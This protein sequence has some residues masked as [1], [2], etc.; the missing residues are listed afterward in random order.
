MAAPAVGIGTGLGIIS[1]IVKT[2][3]VADQGGGHRRMATDAIGLHPFFAG[4]TH[5]DALA[6]LVEGE[7]LGVVQAV[8]GFGYI[9]GQAMASRQMA[10][11][12]FGTTEMS[13]V[14]PGGVLRVHHMAV[15]ADFWLFGEIGHRA[16]DVDQIDEHPDSGDGSYSGGDGG[17]I[18]IF[19]G[20]ILGC[21]KQRGPPS[22]SQAN[23]VPWKIL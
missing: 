11:N 6:K 17:E 14:P 2:V 1:E 3:T 7:S 13:A 15:D 12:A 8:G 4:F 9:S 19:H 21:G 16:G 5:D 10:I 18:G 23:P 20:L 22:H